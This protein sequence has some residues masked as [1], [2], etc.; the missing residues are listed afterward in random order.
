MLKKKMWGVRDLS[1]F[2]KKRIEHEI[3]F[4]Y[5]QKQLERKK[6]GIVY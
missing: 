2:N 6:K 5:I 3:L 4:I 1:N